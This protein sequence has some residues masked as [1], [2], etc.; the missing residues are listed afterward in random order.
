MRQQSIIGAA[1]A[2]RIPPPNPHPLF[3]SMFLTATLRLRLMKSLLFLFSLIAPW[4][5]FADYT[6]NLAVP[7]VPVVNAPE[8]SLYSLDAPAMG[9]H[10]GY[11]ASVKSSRNYGSIYSGGSRVARTQGTENAPGF[12]EP[13]GAVLPEVFANNRGRVAFSGNSGAPGMWTNGSGTLELIAREGSPAPGTNGNFRLLQN[14]PLLGFNDQGKV[15][16]YALIDGA[17]VGT[18]DG[19][20]MGPPGG[21]E[22]LARKGSPAPDSPA[23]TVYQGLANAVINNAGHAAFFCTTS[24]PVPPGL[25]ITGSTRVLYAGPPGFLKAVVRT[26]DPAPG[27]ESGVFIDPMVEPVGFNAKG[28]VAFETLLSSKLPTANFAGRNSAIYIGTAGNLRLVARTGSPAPGTEA[29]FVFTNLQNPVI[30][31]SGE[32]LFEGSASIL[33][34]AGVDGIWTGRPGQLRLIAR[35]GAAA[36]GT[37]LTFDRFFGSLNLSDSGQVL[38]SAGL[39]NAA[40]G[41]SEVLYATDES[42]VLRLLAQS[43]TPVMGSA[44]IT[45]FK[46]LP[47]STY[48][49]ATGDGR[50][51]S[52]N[53]AGTAGFHIIITGPSGLPSSPGREAIITATPAVSPPIIPLEG[54]PAS[55]AGIRGSGVELQVTALGT[56]PATYQWKQAGTPVPGA[57][58][59]MLALNSLGTAARGNYT[60]VVKNAHGFV[61]SAPAT[62]SLPPFI[63]AQPLSQPVSAGSSPSLSVEA[64]GY[65][66]ALTYNWAWQGPGA[67]GFT[68]LGI[69][70]QVLTLPNVTMAQAGRYRVLVSNPDGSTLSSEAVLT[71]APA[72]KVLIERL[73]FKG[74]KASVM[75]GN[76]YFSNPED[77]LLNNAGEVIFRSGLLNSDGSPVQ[78]PPFVFGKQR[79]TYQLFRMSDFNH[80][81]N[82]AGIALMNSSFG[83]QMGPAGGVRVLAQEGEPAPG[84]AGNFIGSNGGM[85]LNQRGLA[86]FIDGVTTDGSYPP[87][88]FMGSPGN[89]KAVL[90]AKQQAPG[91]PAGVMVGG[92]GGEVLNNLGTAASFITLIGPGI[93]D[94]N[95]EGIWTVSTTGAQLLFAEES[96]V[97]GQAVGT[98][99]GSWFPT[100]NSIVRLNDA[101]Q[102][103]FTNRF[104]GPAVTSLNNEGVLVGTPAD[105][106]VV[107]RTGDSADGHKFLALALVNKPTVVNNAGQVLFVA[108]VDPAGGPIE[109]LESLWRWTP[110]TN[111]ASAGTLKM[112]ARQGQQAAGLPAGV[113]YG[114]SDFSVPNFGFV[115]NRVGQ[116]VFRSRLAGPGVNDANNNNS[117]WWMTTAAGESLLVSR[118]GDLFDVG[119]GNMQAVGA[120]NVKTSDLGS[121]GADGLPRILSDAGEFIFYAGVGTFRNTNGIFRAKL[122]GVLA[123]PPLAITRAAD[124]LTAGT[125]TL[126]GQMNPA[127]TG[128]SYFFQYGLTTAYGQQT[129]VRTLTMGDPHRHLSEN[130]TGL[131]PNTTYHFRLVA[132][133]SS[134]SSLGYDQSFTTPAGVVP[135]TFETWAAAAGLTGTDALPLSD[136]DH[137][138]VLNFMEYALKTDPRKATSNGPTDHA[139]LAIQTGLLLTMQY[140]TWSDVTAAGVRYRPELISDG[141]VRTSGFIDEVDPDAEVIPGSTARRTRVTVDPEKDYKFLRLKVS[142]P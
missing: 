40:I 105:L 131:T 30:N 41:Q 72:G 73:V 37:N 34:A 142:K 77:P 9:S 79:D 93:T 126:N 38:F 87:S 120:I 62:L 56:R 26:G 117:G 115:M 83:V 11:Y 91:Q 67:T 32:I 138:G 20:W 4:Q 104:Q 7:T 133:N 64:I 47:S 19:L 129:P 85:A 95:D 71:V 46:M 107:A 5:V 81:L 6:L 12:A 141:E 65:D 128:S 122:P 59:P 68:P 55:V 125:A 35:S 18:I 50:R 96:P 8:G 1:P 132:T 29:G 94:A 114:S 112:I 21:L 52:L 75:A 28:E 60:V 2:R 140:R 51:G 127:E 99:F 106:R 86:V 16:F 118:E 45:T 43:G 54:Q 42:G 17:P 123:A 82:D 23:G 119:G 92:M 63:T 69:T 109:N 39:K 48:S 74:D 33:G 135:L 137:D 124:N 90:T 36:F 134:G 98:N 49:M 78:L 108:T 70:T 136:P 27:T 130:L 100:R 97:Y 113:I 61:E 139:V 88:M 116:I 13:F 58:G 24:Q 15:I 31:A 121:G 80:R 103:A 111:P 25:L 3:Y 76:V 89:L 101:G 84:L 66:S 102:V 10:A 110:G 44:P 22:L 53:S 57:T 14:A